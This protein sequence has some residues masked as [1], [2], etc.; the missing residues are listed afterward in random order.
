MY[1]Y[2][3]KV[4]NKWLQHSGHFSPESVKEHIGQISSFVCTHL[5][6]GVEEGEGEVSGVCREEIR[7][8]GD[9]LGPIL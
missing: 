5:A 7:R 1:M 6:D 8:V 9:H 2:Q 3:G 4:S